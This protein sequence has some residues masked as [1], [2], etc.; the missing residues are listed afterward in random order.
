MQSSK[1]MLSVPNNE[2]LVYTN[3]EFFFFV[4]Q[5]LARSVPFKVMDMA[6]VGTGQ[7]EEWRGFRTK[8]LP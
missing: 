1:Q 8:T 5:K 2:I 4:E 3:S 6:K 7:K